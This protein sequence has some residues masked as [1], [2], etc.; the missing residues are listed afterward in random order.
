MPTL[1]P[2][3]ELTIRDTLSMMPFFIA[4]EGTPEFDAI[5]AV[6][7]E[8]YE[9]RLL[10][11]TFILTEVSMPDGKLADAIVVSEL[12]AACCATL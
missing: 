9:N 3:L 8:Q 5:A 4:I 10:M 12:P 7:K 11:E 6:C 2:T 1:S